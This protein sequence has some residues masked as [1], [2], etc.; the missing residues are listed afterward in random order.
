MRE[1]LRELGAMGKT[2]ILSSHI[3][4]ELAE[5]CD[6]VGIIERGRLVA[7]G[8]L[9]AIQ[10]QIQGGRTLRLRVLSDLSEAQAVLR[11]Q[12]GVGEVYQVNNHLEVPFVGDEEAAADLLADLVAHNVRLSNFSETG[13]DLEEVF[14][15]L[16]KGEVV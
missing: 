10:S 1:L 2:I 5:L 11:D 4:S 8:P 9:E 15:R 7:S 13:N 16:T 14:L 6:A 3:L 12:P